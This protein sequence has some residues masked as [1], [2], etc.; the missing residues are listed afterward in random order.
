MPIEQPA[1]PAVVTP[2][3]GVPLHRQLFLVLHDEISRGTIQPGDALP[4][5]QSLCEQFGVSRITVRRA[6]ADLAEEGLI[7]RRQGVGSFVREDLPTKSRPV[8]SHL[9]GLRQAQFETAVEVI[10]LGLRTAPPPIGEALG[11]GE[12]LHVVRLRRERRTHEPLMITEAWLPPELADR[13]TPAALR[14]S[15]L[16]DLLGQTGLELGRI[17]SELTAELAGPVNARLLE[18]PVSSALI[19]INRLAY[20]GGT[21][22]HYLTITLTPTRSR[23]LL[24]HAATDSPQAVA[25]AHDVRHS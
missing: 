8:G 21:P 15:A 17:D 19:R 11:P 1:Q 16:Y 14:E 23:V 9:D 7:E 25:I 18:V 5:E 6:L 22:H 3:V 2:G 24:N 12:K 20:S 4:T 13:I 10:D